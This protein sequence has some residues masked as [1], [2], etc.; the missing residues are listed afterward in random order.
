M[1]QWG[2]Y[3]YALHGWSYERI[4]DHYYPGTTLGI[5]P[6]PT[7]R[8]LLADGKRRVELGSA[9][10]W[11]VV[12][13]E[14]RRIELPPGRLVVPASLEI[15]GRA[16]SAP[17]TFVPGTAPLELGGAAYRGKLLVFSN[18]ERLQVVNAVGME[19]YVRGVVGGEMPP[20]W[21]Q[22]A[23]EAQAVA[24]RSFA[25][26][27]LSTVVTAST[28]DVYD[29]TRSQVYGGIGAETPSTDEAVAATARH[30][31]LFDGKVALTVFSSSSGGTTVSA[32]EGFGF[33][34]PYLVSVPDPY[35][36]L[37]PNHDWGPVLIS[38]DAAGRA[39]GLGGPISDLATTADAS[40]HIAAVTATGPGGERTL[41]GTQ[42]EADLGLRSTWFSFA[43][44]TLIPPPDPIP[45]GS[46]A[47]LTGSVRGLAG[48]TLEA[49]PAG[50]IWQPVGRVSPDA[51][52]A[53]A[54]RVTPNRATEYR[55]AVGSIRGALVK[56]A[57]S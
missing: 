24:A 11:R 25:L 17:L 21:P 39:L 35:D 22:A 41:T 7:V 8:V 57:V 33:S 34:E 12:D 48:V 52:G 28:F 36:T 45:A 55:L 2:A 30:V 27:R 3:G 15:D 26:S 31:V 40:G 29:D 54:I 37:S 4:L 16:L 53:F 44:L 32:A 6:S 51:E 20:T 56:L 23:L 19:S 46:W 9:A 10:S 42:V 43:W 13:A 14:R 1:A 38:A 47:V 49:K 5:S 18:G 50:G